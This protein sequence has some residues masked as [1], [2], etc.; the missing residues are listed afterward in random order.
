MSWSQA[1]RSGV[2]ESAATHRVRAASADSYWR[3]KYRDAGQSAF[4]SVQAAGPSLNYQW[5]AAATASGGP[6]TNLLNGSK[7][8]GVSGLEEGLQKRP[9]LFVGTLTES[10]QERRGVDAVPKILALLM[11]TDVAI[12]LDNHTHRFGM[13]LAVMRIDGK[14]MYS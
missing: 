2:R 4:F 12:R 14:P 10:L 1:T 11:R 9:E 5:Q 13:R 7:F 8:T 3:V 6:Y